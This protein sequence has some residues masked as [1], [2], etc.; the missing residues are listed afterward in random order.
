MPYTYTSTTDKTYYLKTRR[1]KKGNLSYYLTSKGDGDCLDEVPAGYEIFERYDTGQ[2]FIRKVRKS[3]IEDREVEIIRQELRKNESLYDFKLDICGDEI[4]IYVKEKGSDTEVPDMLRNLMSISG[5]DPEAAWYKF[6]R[7]EEQMR[8]S[9]TQ[10]EGQREFIVKRY[11]Y[12][13]FIDDW[14]VIDSGSD[15][16]ALAENNLYHLGKKSY[17]ELFGF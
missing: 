8:V 3:H 13:S 11:C 9:L 1:T 5:K 12:R 15:I 17:F 4:R 7:Y 6:R 10:P 16:Q 14:M 2:A